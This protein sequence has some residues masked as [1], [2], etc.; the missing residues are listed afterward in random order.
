M[1]NFVP[2]ERS[3][4]WNSPVTQLLHWRSQ[5]VFRFDHFV[6]IFKVWKCVPLCFLFLSY[7]RILTQYLKKKTI[8][9]TVSWI[10]LLAILYTVHTKIENLNFVTLLLYRV[11][12][13]EKQVYIETGPAAFHSGCQSFI[14]SSFYR[15]YIFWSL[16]TFHVQCCQNASF[17][18]IRTFLL[19]Y[20]AT[21]SCNLNLFCICKFFA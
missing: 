3:T 10:W 13:L 14:F 6:D 1:L 19:L 18:W 15:V 17:F 12:L 2:G 20:I 4:F 16:I 21:H 5:T 8:H 7:L 9:A 11:C